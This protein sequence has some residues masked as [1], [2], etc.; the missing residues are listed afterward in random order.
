VVDESEIAGAAYD[1]LQRIGEYLH[2]IEART[3]RPLP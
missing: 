3:W 1:K 2:H